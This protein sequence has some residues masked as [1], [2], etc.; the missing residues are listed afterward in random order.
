M[1]GMPPSEGTCVCRAAK[2][3]AEYIGSLGRF[4]F[5]DVEPYEHMGVLIVD[6]VLQAGLNYDN[7][8]APRAKSVLDQFPTAQT[9]SMFLAAFNRFGPTKM[10]GFAEGKKTRTIRE[11]CDLLA[12]DG[13]QT[14]SDLRT[15][16]GTPSARG[17]I[18]GVF[19]IGPKTHSYIHILCGDPREVAVDTHL[20][21]FLEDAGIEPIDHEWARQV[22]ICAAEL[23]GVDAATLDHSVWRFM[24]GGKPVTKKRCEV[25]KNET[26]KT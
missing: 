22:Y 17:K 3:L 10:I 21:R 23:L 24:A 25:T 19:G 16:L 5:L 1:S 7:V 18:L 12:R 14:V 2:R 20:W 8:V 9:T 4:E 11:L 15:W 6:A 26:P 13:V